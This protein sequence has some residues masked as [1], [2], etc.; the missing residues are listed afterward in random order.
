MKRFLTAAILALPDIPNHICLRIS[1]VFQELQT[2]YNALLQMYGEKQ[3]ETEELKL[4]LQDIKNM[5][6]AQVLVNICLIDHQ[7]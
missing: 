2:K 3:E 5:Y 4:D 7:S 1:L 6:K